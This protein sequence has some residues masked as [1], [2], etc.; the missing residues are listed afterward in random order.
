MKIVV[1]AVKDWLVSFFSIHESRTLNYMPL[2]SWPGHLV[3][4]VKG[5]HDLRV[6][7]SSHKVNF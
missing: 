2:Q 7:K 6:T 1:L 3:A 4:A 5:T